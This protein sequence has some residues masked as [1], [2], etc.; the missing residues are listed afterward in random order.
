MGVVRSTG[1]WH[2]PTIA[3]SLIS[4]TR[5]ADAGYEVE[6]GRTTC[7]IVKGEAKTKLG[8]RNGSLYQLIRNNG[9][10]G[11]IIDARNTANIGL[12]TKQSPR[13]TLE[14]WHRRLGHRSL[15]HKTLLYLSSKVSDISISETKTI[16]PKICGICGMGKQH[17]EAETRTRE[18][19]T[20]LLQAIHTDLCG[21]MQTPTLTGEP[22]FIA[23]TDEMSGRISI[24]LMTSKDG[25]LAAFQA[26]RARAEKTSGK[27]IKSL[28]SDGGGEFLNKRF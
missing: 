5:I 25:A 2:V 22:Y 8:Y 24:S 9:P 16:P 6:F 1:V 19:A 20:E 14:T 13:A 17:K 15:D 7:S 23:F 28:R 4:V 3:A 12:S 18:R 10:P 21:P 26:Y 27:Q 11:I